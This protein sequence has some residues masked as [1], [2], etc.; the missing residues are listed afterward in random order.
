MRQMRVMIVDGQG[1]GIGRILVERIKEEIPAC[2]II[3]VGTN[4]VA[5]ANMIKSGGILGATG[6]NAV[7]YNCMRVNYIIAPIGVYFANAMYGEITPTI[8]NSIANSPAEKIAIP[9]S[10]CHVNIIGLDD[11]PMSAQI[12]KAIKILKES[13]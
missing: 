12:D 5:T 13:N 9:V 10:R 4:A 6:E 2:E 8:A 11:L 1:G 3:A 7:A